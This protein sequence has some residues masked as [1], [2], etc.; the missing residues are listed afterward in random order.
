MA[1]DN[2]PFPSG[3][4][5]ACFVTGATGFVA[6]NLVDEL[7]RR[8][9]EVYALHRL[10]SKRADML[11]GLPHAQ[12]AGTARG[13]LVL[14]EGDLGMSA[15]AF[16][17]LVPAN[18]DVLYHICHVDEPTVHP[19]RKLAVPG[20]QPEGAE[21]HLRVNRDAMR[22]V[23]HAASTRGVR[24]VVYCSSWSAYGRQPAG[25][26]VSE[27]TESRAGDLVSGSAVPYFQCKH[28]LEQQLCRAVDEGGVSAVI[29]QPCSV[30]GR[31][32]EAGWS[33]IFGKLLQTN[34]SLPGLPGASSFVDVQD[35]AAAFVAAA[36]V[37][38]GTGEAYVVGGTNASNL[39]MQR[40]MAVLVGTPAP[41]KATPAMVLRFLAQW[42]ECL[43]HIPWLRWLRVKPDAIGSPWL[44]AKITQDQ[45]TQSTAA[46]EALGHR[47]RP[48]EDILKRNFE[49]LVASGRLEP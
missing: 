30:F 5:R 26:W 13:K 33:Q 14:V 18:T 1:P 29:L 2:P 7:L 15:E 23:V 11:L 35:L 4:G 46:C 22:N 27:T 34:G 24:R 16:A 41:R 21:E 49:W 43:L 32:G 9:W 44:V 36:D 12:P 42:N 19:M 31:Y 39:E 6:L 20:F 8:D 28:A 45:C 10:G 40:K 48:L 47:P 38:P 3:A 17:R 25:T 37:G